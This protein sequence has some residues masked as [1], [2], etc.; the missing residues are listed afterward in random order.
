MKRLHA[1]WR[2]EYVKAPKAPCKDI[3]ERLPK[4]NDD[5]KN[6]IVIRKN[7][8][9]LVLNTYPYN[10]GHLL[11]IPY[12]PVAL[13]SD[14]NAEERNELME[15]VAIAET[16]LRRALQPDGFNIGLNLGAAAGAGIPNHLHVHIIPRWKGD[17]NFMPVIG[18]VRV[19]PQALNEMWKRLMSHL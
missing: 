18:E 2:L 3:F 10:A 5:E 9:Y 1:Y 6:Y 17:T 19:L 8:T 14:L 4:D 15:L 13:L 16:L 12:R 11:A 7:H